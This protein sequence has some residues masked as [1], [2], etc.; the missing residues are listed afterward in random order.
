MASAGRKPRVSLIDF[1]T[2]VPSPLFSYDAQLRAGVVSFNRCIFNP[3][4]GLTIGSSQLTVALHR[5]T[6]CTLEWRAPESDRLEKKSIRDGLCHINGANRPLFMAWEDSF[7]VSIVAIDDRFV[8]ATQAEVFG[9]DRLDLPTRIGIGDSLL[10]RLIE[11]CDAEIDSH[12]AN[13]RLFA[14]GLATALIVHLFRSQAKPPPGT[15]AKG[16]LTPRALRQVLEYIDDHLATDVGLVELAQIARISPHHFGT[17][18][19]LSMGI[20]PHRYLVGRR[21]HK[22]KELLLDGE[23]SAEAIATASGFSSQSHMTINFRRIV[24]TTPSRFRRESV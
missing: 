1:N 6:V 24:G 12:P 17:A 21:V 2:G 13:S 10:R 16:G 5:G 11:V 20:P 23:M 8:K 18:F 15:V 22:A 4:S 14:E 7:E 9:T 19:K 3:T